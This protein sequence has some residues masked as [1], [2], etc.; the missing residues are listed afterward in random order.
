MKNVPAL[1]MNLLLIV[2]FLMFMLAGTVA[3]FPKA[4]QMPVE[5]PGAAPVELS[6]KV[7]ETMDSGGY[8]YI[9]LE[10]DQ[11]KIWAAAPTMQVAVGDELTLQSGQQMGPFTSK[12]LDRTFDTIIFSAGPV[13]QVAAI[14][15]GHPAIPDEAAALPSGH[16]TLPAAMTA[17][18]AAPVTA[19]PAP[20]SGKVVETFDA[21]GYTYI[22]LEKDGQKSW[23][24]VP[25][26]K[27]E[28]GS[29]IGVRPGMEMGQFTSKTLNRTFDNIVF[30]SGILVN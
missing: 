29:E 25:P 2:L 22:C 15:A 4:A 30:S 20:I 16:P 8:T 17:E 19:G 6:G 12:S 27:V 5:Q 21:G 28:V 18:A 14:P 9:C 3:A 1:P 7:V 24:A 13:Q 11:Q 10:K 26:V 23:A